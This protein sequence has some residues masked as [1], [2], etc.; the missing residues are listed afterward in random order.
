MEENN[1]TGDVGSIILLLFI[2]SVLFLIAWFK[3][4]APFLSERENIKMEMS[5]SY[6]EK[7]YRYW[8]RELRRLYLRSIPVIGR[9]F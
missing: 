9:F 5:R 3:S 6:S 8:K 2:L 4:I 7:E 1:I